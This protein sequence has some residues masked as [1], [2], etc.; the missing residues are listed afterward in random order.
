MF[1][2]PEDCPECGEWLTVTETNI[3]ITK[4]CNCGH[5]ETEQL[6]GLAF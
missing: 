1:Q 5:E 4:I 6:T 3:E 2:Y